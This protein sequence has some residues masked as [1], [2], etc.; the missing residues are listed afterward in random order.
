MCTQA[1]ALSCSYL[2]KFKA[3]RDPVLISTILFSEALSSW[4]GSLWLQLPSSFTISHAD[5]SWSLESSRIIE[6]HMFTTHILHWWLGLE[7]IIMTWVSDD[8]LAALKLPNNRETVSKASE[9]NEGGYQFLI[10]S[11][12]GLGVWRA[13]LQTCLANSN[14]LVTFPWPV[15]WE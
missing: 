9:V 13:S 8:L 11:H 10:P 12:L 2:W 15:K 1:L 3:T 14:F 5:G 6:N 4:M 7:S